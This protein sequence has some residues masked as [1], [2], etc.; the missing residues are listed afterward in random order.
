MQQ[1]KEQL[2]ELQKFVDVEHETLLSNLNEVWSKN[3]ADKLDAGDT[4]AIVSLQQYDK[5]TLEAKLGSNESRYREGDIVRLYLESPVFGTQITQ[6]RIDHVSE[7]SWL[8]HVQKLD[9]EALFELSEGCYA[10]PCFIDLKKFFDAALEEIAESKNGREVVL[11]LFSG[12]L[13]NNSVD[14]YLYDEII[15]RIEQEEFNENQQHAIAL[16]LAV[17]YLA[18]IQGPPGTGKTHVIAKIAELL[19]ERGEHVLISSHTHM[20]INNALNK[21]AEK[22]PDTVKIGNPNSYN[23][24]DADVL[25][26]ALMEDWQDRPDHGYVIG[27]TPFA[28]C[29]N[30]LEGYSFDTIIFDEASQVTLPLAIMAMRTGKRFIF[31]GDHQQLPPVILSES[32]LSSES[33]FAKL[34]QNNTEVS[35]MLNETY[36]MNQWLADWPS[37]T[38]YAGRL[39]AKGGNQKRH[40][41][42]T[43]VQGPVGSVLAPEEPLVYIP[44]PGDNK[45]NHNDSEAT[46]VEEIILAAI[47]SGLDSKEIGVVVPF[48]LHGKNIRKKLAQH[49][50]DQIIVADTVERMQGQEREFII[51]SLCSTHPGYLAAVAEFLFMAER[52]NVSI[53]RART[54]LVLIGPQ[55]DSSQFLSADSRTKTL[56]DQ[57]ISLTEHAAQHKL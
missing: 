8:L 42:I 25:R 19:V 17:N 48:R 56:I 35:V 53:T 37:R 10:D 1:L 22:V 3:L 18:C 6:A 47:A 33:A 4:Q 52:I 34:L 16:G 57:Y 38:Y 49:Q 5:S 7:D 44:S 27:A 50:L 13:A 46:L 23:S 43:P 40:L 55:V 9:S 51:I 41:P 26:F 24:L 54:K 30:R 11:P 28:T 36:R 2:D 39:Q 20:A 14:D 12:Q 29:S 15:E 31:V 45:R 32:V 21:I